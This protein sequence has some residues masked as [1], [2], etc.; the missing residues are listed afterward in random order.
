MRIFKALPSQL[1]LAL[2]PKDPRR[3]VKTLR[4][5]FSIPIGAFSFS[6]YLYLP[7]SI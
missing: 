2:M 6:S 7:L 3:A 1:I 5:I 4:K